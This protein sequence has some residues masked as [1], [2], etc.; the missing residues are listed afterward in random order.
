[1]QCHSSCFKALFEFRISLVRSSAIW[2]AWNLT[3]WVWDL[4]ISK[5]RKVRP[6]MHTSTRKP[7]M[8]LSTTR[9]P[10]KLVTTI[11]CSSLELEVIWRTITR[12]GFVASLRV[13]IWMYRV[14][15]SAYLRLQGITQRAVISFWPASFSA[16][17]LSKRPRGTSRSTRKPHFRSWVRYRWS[18]R[19]LEMKVRM[20]WLRLIDN[21]SCFYLKV[22]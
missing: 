10:S 3:P 8:L 7:T 17:P 11:W 19:K 18:K 13:M 22:F 14:T 1:M 15:T 9:S 5:P 12:D 2:N 4:C 16:M 21:L 6:E 20:W